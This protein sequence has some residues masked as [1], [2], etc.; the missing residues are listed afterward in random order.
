[1]CYY[2]LFHSAIQSSPAVEKKMFQNL[3]DICPLIYLYRSLKSEKLK[4]ARQHL[5]RHLSKRYTDTS[6]EPKKK[7]T[8]SFTQRHNRN[9]S[10]TAAPQVQ[11][12]IKTADLPA[13][14]VLSRSRTDV[15]FIALS[16]STQLAHVSR[17]RSVLRCWHARASALMN[18]GM[19][20]VAD[21][22]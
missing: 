4:P 1:M 18:V 7:K 11:D 16:C 6:D 13:P 2:A 8:L 15:F 10:L 17:S 12:N 3:A 14:P 9:R 21:T 20:L 5:L 19:F 22:F